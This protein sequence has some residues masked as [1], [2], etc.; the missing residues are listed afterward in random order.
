MRL[1][2]PNPTSDALHRLAARGLSEAAGDKP[3]LLRVL[4]DLFVMRPTHSADEIRQFAEIALRLLPEAT[5]AECEHAA[6]ALCDHLSAPTG[7]MDRLAQ[8]F[9][10]GALQLYARC[11]A[12]ST[13]VLEYAA[14]AGDE[15]VGVALAGRSDLGPG[16]ISMLASREEIAVLRALARNSAAP[17]AG[18]ALTTLIARARSDFELAFELIARAPHRPET[19]ALFMHADNRRRAM[20]IAR[21]REN[22]GETEPLSQAL[23]HGAETT[24]RRFGRSGARHRGGPR[25]RTAHDRAALAGA[26]RRNRDAHLPVRR[27]AGGACAGA[28]VGAGAIGRKPLAGRGE[29]HF[30]RDVRTPADD[31]APRDAARPDRTAVDRPA[32]TS[33]DPQA[34]QRGG[35]VEATGVVRLLIGDDSLPATHVVPLPLVGRG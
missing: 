33:D 30:R 14:A 24:L 34:A 27:S 26:A 31:D 7:L 28:R 20:M 12:L 3:L 17:L 15:A 11:R 32:G 5:A 8:R 19:L 29:T 22:A 1:F 35:V 9:G 18:S 6:T 2:A 4:T 25:R 16:L 13:N 10:D 23:E 21:T